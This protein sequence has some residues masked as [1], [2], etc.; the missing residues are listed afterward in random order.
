MGQYQYIKELTSGWLS[1][2]AEPDEEWESY[3]SMHFVVLTSL[4][5][6]MRKGGKKNE[7]MTLCPSL[8]QSQGRKL[9]HCQKPERN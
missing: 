9:C 2:K 4:L 1:S 6:Q 5:S 8:A 3:K 7:N